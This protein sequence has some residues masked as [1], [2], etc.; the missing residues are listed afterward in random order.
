MGTTVATNA[1]L[2]RQG[3]RVALLVTHGF[4]DLLHIGT[5]ARSDLFDLVSTSMAA[6][7]W[8][9]GLYTQG[10][11]NLGRAVVGRLIDGPSPH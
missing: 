8:G 5:Q 1:L 6:G 4:R 9:R 7:C 2:E 11:C 3:E 10:C